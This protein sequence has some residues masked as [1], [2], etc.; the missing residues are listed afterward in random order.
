[1]TAPTLGVQIGDGPVLFGAPVRTGDLWVGGEYLSN[2][3]HPAWLGG[4]TADKYE[5]IIRKAANAA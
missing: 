2:K 1:M 3:I 5:R 4:L